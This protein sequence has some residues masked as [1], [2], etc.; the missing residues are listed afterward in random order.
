MLSPLTRQEQIVIV[1]LAN[2]KTVKTISGEM[3][4]AVKTVDSHKGNLMRKLD[5]HSTAA[6]V[7]YAIKHKLIDI[8][9]CPEP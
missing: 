9:E 8:S 2:G 4:I 6:V 1:G 7:I 5:L 3:G